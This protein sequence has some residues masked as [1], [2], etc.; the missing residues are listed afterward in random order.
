MISG[1]VWV[2]K[3]LLMFLGGVL[4]DLVD[5]VGDGGV[6]VMVM[7]LVNGWVVIEEALVSTTII[8]V[9]FVLFHISVEIDVG[10]DVV[11]DSGRHCRGADVTTNAHWYR[12]KVGEVARWGERGW[13]E[14]RPR[15]VAFCALLVTLWI[16]PVSPSRGHARQW[17]GAR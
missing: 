6:L 14:A 16:G 9:L 15:A 8:V 4:V 1:L 17:G 11:L 3:L 13:G 10:S 12:A 5:G 2:L 7:V